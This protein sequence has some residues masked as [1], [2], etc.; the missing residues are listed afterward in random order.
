[1]EHLD[2]LGLQAFVSVAELGSFRLAASRLN[3]SATAVSRRV[4]KLEQ[5]VGT[6]LLS[7]T[8]RRVTLTPLG[9]DFLPRAQCLIESLEQSFEDLRALGRF[10]ERAISIGCLPTF[11]AYYLPGILA[12]FAEK[13]A[14]PIQ[15]QDVTATQIPDLVRSGKID[16][17]IG[18]LGADF[19]DL[20]TTPLY[21]EPIVALV[22]PDAPLAKKAA[23]SWTDLTD[24]RLITLGTLSGI[25]R[26]IDASIKPHAIELQWSYEVQRVSTAL[27]LAKAGLGVAVLPIVTEQLTQP[28][29][30]AVDLFEP[31]VERKIGLIRRTG[32]A[33]S[34][35]AKMLHDI[36]I[37]HMR[38]VLQT[39]F[40][41]TQSVV[42]C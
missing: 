6:P 40:V 12:K 2:V 34:P 37:P 33:L 25:R 24:Q 9:A 36:I 41:S 5:S 39:K 16:F 11:A 42:N 28:P 27:N 1:M 22:S 4:Q 10:G 14:N 20:T 18:F 15:I 17:A 3:L 35:A 26:L 30:I 13:S 8:T 29:L 19:H 21:D 7:R 31:K 38:N 32:I 23:V